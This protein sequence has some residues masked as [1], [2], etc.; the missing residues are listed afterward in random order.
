[1]DSIDCKHYRLLYLIL[2]LHIYKGSYNP[3]LSPDDDCWEACN[4]SGLYRPHEDRLVLAAANVMGN[5]Y[6]DRECGINP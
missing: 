4:C 5:S 2:S 3:G 1:M 6:S